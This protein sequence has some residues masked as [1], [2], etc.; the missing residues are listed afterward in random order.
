MAQFDEAWR[1]IRGRLSEGTE[2]RNWSYDSGYT[3]TTT[4]IERLNYDEIVVTGD[5]TTEPRPVARTG[6]KKVFEFWDRYRQGLVSRDEI[7]KISRNSTYI[8]SILHW[9]GQ[10]A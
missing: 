9:L 10:A 4:R 5:R 3:G 6:F 7:V 8:L 1:E 2:V